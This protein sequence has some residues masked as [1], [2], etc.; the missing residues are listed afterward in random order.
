MMVL[1]SFFPR[2]ALL[3]ALFLA[4]LTVVPGNISVVETNSS[5]VSGT[6][7]TGAVEIDHTDLEVLQPQ[8]GATFRARALQR[9]A[10]GDGMPPRV[11]LVADLRPT[12]IASPVPR[13]PLR[14]PPPRF[15]N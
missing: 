5:D 11:I 4:P 8:R 14:R 13:P 1:R 2:I 9:A 12:R 6:F 7:H 3:F 15:L 10:M